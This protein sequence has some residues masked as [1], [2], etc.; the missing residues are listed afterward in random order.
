MA[1]ERRLFEL[2]RWAGELGLD[3]WHDAG[4]VERVCAD[5]A[6]L[7][8]AAQAAA[9]AGE[10]HVGASLV[11]V[12]AEAEW[13]AG[14]LGVDMDLG[15]ALA[16]AP[17]GEVSMRLHAA[18]VSC[19]D[20]LAHARASAEALAAADDAPL[21]GRGLAWLLRRDHDETMDARLFSLPRGD[22]LVPILGALLVERGQ[23]A[24]ALALVEACTAA[25]LRHECAWVAGR[26][27]IG[28]GDLVA[29][30]AVLEAA[31]GEARGAVVGRI[32]TALADVL[33]RSGE[34]E[35]AP[36]LLR[37]GSGIDQVVVSAR[38]TLANNGPQES[39]QE[40]RRALEHADIADDGLGRIRLVVE[41]ARVLHG[42]DRTRSGLRLLGRALRSKR[43]W[44]AA[45]VDVFCCR[46][47]LLV[48][49]S[50]PDEAAS[51]VEAALQTPLPEFARF[52]LETLRSAER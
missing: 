29:A 2:F 18:T 41:L 45:A 20:D 9:M 47:E 19:T 23:Y 10:A 21:V 28:M 4:V 52:R 12:L 51:E 50:R 15:W 35:G 17:L 33:V 26:A 3:W 32:R 44:T 37:G 43:G 34:H 22:R 25:A 27:R 49:S 7:G 14:P 6:N 11:A 13:C 36:E 42:Q 16:L 38:L 24:E 31:L 40:L 5:A 1:C 39:E 46:H 8:V 48:A 30:R